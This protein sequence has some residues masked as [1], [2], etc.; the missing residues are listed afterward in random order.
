[1]SL[2]TMTGKW[3]RMS[4]VVAALTVFLAFAWAHEGT[5]ADP[6]DE[7][8][9]WVWTKKFPKPSWFKWGKEFHPAKP[10]RGGY[11]REA[12]PGYIGL[13]NPNHWPVNDWGSI[14]EMYDSLTRTDG[15]LKPTVPWLAESWIYTTP[16]TVVMKFKRGIRFSDGSPF[17][18]KVVKY[19]MEWIQNKK[20]GAFSRAWL[21]PIIKMEVIDEYTLKW[22]FDRVWGG[23]LGTIAYP[24][25]KIVSA[26]ALK[27]DAALIQAK[28]LKGRVKTIRKKVAKAEKKAENGGKKALKKVKKLKKKLAKLEKELAEALV[29]SEGAIPVDKRGVGTGRYTVE[30]ARP[31]NYLKLKRNPDW[32]FGGS[33]G[34]PDMPYFDGRIK[35][36]IPDPTVRLANFRSGKVDRLWL[37]PEQV[38]LLKR[39]PNAVIHPL[40]GNSMSGMAFNATSGPCRDLR[41]RKAI[42]HAID[43]RAIVGGAL[44]GYAEMA[45]SLFPGVHWCHNPKLKPVAYD[46]EL[47]KKLLAE[48]GYE[49][50]LTIKGFIG[51]TYT[52][53]RT[54][55][56][57]IKNMLA[58]V[59]VDWQYEVLDPV[60]MDDR[61]KNAEFDFAQGGW[62]F[63]Q[64][65]DLMLSSLYEPDG[66]WNN[67]IKNNEAAL[68]LIRKARAETDFAKRRKMYY[69]IEK[70][71]YNN[72]ESAWLYYGNFVMAL[73]KNVMGWNT[74][75]YLQGRDSYTDTHLLWFKEGHP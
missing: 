42:S 50:G 9:S 69:E 40:P 23:F 30:E 25:G 2:K 70:I 27:A 68:R 31:G 51:N 26:K 34:H 6:A 24:P 45:S 18:A 47:A 10:V 19:Q 4:A 36:V 32:W 56:Q 71:V 63:V 11:F 35:T 20:N 72:Y 22:T 17:N 74:K 46:R 15:E 55:A 8:P 58:Q 39:D 49:N 12:V 61:R 5:A 41:V 53:T 3:I 75:M 67:G 59:N 60:A 66:N 65:P 33:I 13:M 14:D 7:K 62:S 44:F 1:M 16:K 29:L 54:V 37:P 43:R 57:A 52:T 21:D 38:G 64:E 28:K 73:K 48:A